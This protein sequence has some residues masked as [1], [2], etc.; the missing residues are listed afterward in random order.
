MSLLSDEFG[1]YFD[2]HL[3]KS[4]TCGLFLCDLCS[5]FDWFGLTLEIRAANGELDEAVNYQ[6][7]SAKDLVGSVF[8]HGGWSNFLVWCSSYG[9]SLRSFGFLILLLSRLCSARRRK[10]S[11][12]LMLH[13]CSLAER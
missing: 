4:E 7:M 12:L 6:V 3:I 10:L 11:S 1:D 13:L 9:F 2:S 5:S 8:T